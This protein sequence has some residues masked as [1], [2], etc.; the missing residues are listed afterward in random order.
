M[1]VWT[2]IGL[3]INVCYV[4]AAEMFSDIDV[5]MI[6][7][8][9]KPWMWV[10]FL[11]NVGC[12]LAEGFFSGSEIAIVAIDKIKLRHLVKTGSTGARLAQRMLQQPERFLGTTLVGT[13][14]SVVSGSV[15]LTTTLAVL[16][17]DISQVVHQVQILVT[18]ILVPCSLILGEIVPKSIFQQHAETLVP[19]IAPVLNIAG[20]IFY[21][22]V[23]VVT[24]IATALLR[25]WGVEKKERKQTLTR[26]ELKYLIHTDTQGTIAD[27]HRKEMIQGV[28]EFGDTIVKEIMAPLVN[29]F[30]LEKGTSVREAIQKIQENGF[31]R[32]PIYENRIDNIIGVIHAFDLLRATPQDITIDKFIRKAYYIPETIQLDNLFQNMQRHHTQIAIV[33]D[34]YGGSSGIV[35]TEDMLE[36]IVGKIEDEFDVFSG[37]MYKVLPDGSYR[38]NARMRIDEINQQLSLN[39]P[40]GIEGMFETLGGFLLFEFQRVPYIGEKIEYNGLIFKIEEANDRSVIR[41]HVSRVTL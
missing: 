19:K 25:S 38:I 26:E 8:N 39:L 16:L 14:I 24:K 7:H 36:K 21:P 2:W 17:A 35:T 29:V 37:E 30:A 23:F 22:L 32:I 41:V 3:T 6:G 15:M 34:E 31:S 33:V 11:F 12:I 4:L 13:N 9:L 40:E 10:A 18:L 20:K 28:F 1:L 5:T 27:Q